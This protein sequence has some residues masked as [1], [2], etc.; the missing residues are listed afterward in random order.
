M[1][2]ASFKRCSVRQLFEAKVEN[3]AA[4]ENARQLN[5]TRVKV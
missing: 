5:F 1:L 3:G 4:Y 2:N